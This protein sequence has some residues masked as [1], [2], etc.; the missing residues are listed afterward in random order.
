MSAAPD[1]LELYD[2]SS[3]GDRLLTGDGLKLGRFSTTVQVKSVCVAHA[4][5][6]G[7]TLSDDDKDALDRFINYVRYY[8]AVVTETLS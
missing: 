8:I 2:A 7:A 4:A 3:G 5:P 6:S 1:T